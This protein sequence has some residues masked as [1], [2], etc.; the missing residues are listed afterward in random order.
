MMA[1]D[2]VAGVGLVVQTQRREGRE[3]PARGAML[4]LYV[5]TQ[6]GVPAIIQLSVFSFLLQSS[7]QFCFEMLGPL[8]DILE[9]GCL[10]SRAYCS[11][12][13]RLLSMVARSP[14]RDMISESC[15]MGS[16]RLICSRWVQV[17]AS[18]GRPSA[19]S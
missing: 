16:P 18:L 2:Y 7:C 6:S 17:L 12:L 10:I 14:L 3:W 9:I 4:V 1:P 13:G 8:C 19:P 11:W 5:S 15:G